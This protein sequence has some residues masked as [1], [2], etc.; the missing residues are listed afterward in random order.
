MFV[1]SKIIYKKFGECILIS[2]NQIDMI[3]TTNVGPRII[4]FGKHK[5]MN[6]LFEDLNDNF[7]MDDKKFQDMFGKNQI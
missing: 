7:H 6:F 2:D 1:V 3:V 5:G 4:F